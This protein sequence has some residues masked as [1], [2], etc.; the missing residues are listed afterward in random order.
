MVETKNKKSIFPYLVV[1]TGIMGCFGPCALC[2]SCAGIFLL[3]L[4]RLWVLVQATSLCI[5]P[6]CFLLL[7][8][9]FLLKEN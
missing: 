3:R 7:Q 6:L 2:L 9:F 5:L 8:L 1:M 4:V